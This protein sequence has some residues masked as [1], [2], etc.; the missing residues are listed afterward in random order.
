M[1]STSIK[2]LTPKQQL[3][4]DLTANQPAAKIKFHSLE[5]LAFPPELQMTDPEFKEFM[6]AIL[7]ARKSSKEPP[8]M[9]S[10]T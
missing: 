2:G 8:D 1:S 10:E 7:E 9:D 6:D 5:D 4:F 3:A